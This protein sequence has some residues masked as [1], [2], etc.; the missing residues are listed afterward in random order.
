MHLWTKWLQAKLPISLGGMG[1][2]GD[3]DHA[4]SAHVSSLLSSYTLTIQLQGG[5]DENTGG[6]VLPEQLLEDISLRLEK[7]PWLKAF[8][9]EQKDAELQSRQPQPQPSHATAGI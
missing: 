1:L 5:Q 4:S 7:V 6:I 8:G 3:E 9:P 2:R